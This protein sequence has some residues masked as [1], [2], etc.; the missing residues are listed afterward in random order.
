[1]NILITGGASGLG[2]AIVCK[3]AEN[4]NNMIYFTYNKSLEKAEKI[5]LKYC[6]AKSLKCDFGNKEEIQRL[7]NE[8]NLIDLDILINN[9]YN[10][11]FLK[12]YFHKIP[13]NDF[14][15]EFMENIIPTIK[16]TQACINIFRKKKY[17]KIITILTSAVSA[18]PL[19]SSIYVANKAYLGELTKV[20]ASENVKYNISSNSVSPTFMQTALTSSIDERIVEQMTNEHPLKKLL[21]VE[22]V[23]ETIHYLTEA[24]LHL[25]GIDIT[26]NAAM[27][28]K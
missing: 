3:L 15:V 19:G 22:E 16:I 26:L 13:S 6:N 14:S 4:E 2:A 10:G 24:S 20:W 23:A 7:I 17:G 21:T 25:N 12:T 9:A 27:N 5:T 18:P 8:I 11:S 28:L 1:M